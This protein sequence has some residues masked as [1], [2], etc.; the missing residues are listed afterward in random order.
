MVGAGEL[1]E[2]ALASLDEA[3]V[4]GVLD[5]RCDQAGAAWRGALGGRGSVHEVHVRGAV[6]GEVPGGGGSEGAL[7]DDEDAARRHGA[8]MRGAVQ[9][10]CWPGSRGGG[11]S[12]K[13]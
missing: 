13:P 8:C 1:V 4:G 5:E 2:Q 10:F 12:R 7:P 9:R 3:D 6:A 11:R